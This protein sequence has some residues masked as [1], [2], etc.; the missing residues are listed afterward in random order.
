MERA[1]TVA[2]PDRTS[3]FA[4]WSLQRLNIQ[5]YGA[6]SYDQRRSVSLG[7]RLTT[8]LCM[9]AFL[10]A[11]VAGSAV[12]LG[13][14]VPIALIG[15]LTPRHPVDFV[16]QYAVRHLVGGSPLPPN[17]PERRLAFL[18]AAPCVLLVAGLVGLGW[19]IAAYIVAAPLL[20]ACA[21]VTLTHLC[22]P[23]TAVA[24]ARGRLKALW[25]EVPAR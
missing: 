20:V 25:C 6:L 13:A 23:G 14:L 15:G 10:A 19:T 11:L 18:I 24:L 1:T 22:L 5:G 12:A 4:R 7:L 9:T 21:T 3:N 16:W 17:P 2:A 8:G